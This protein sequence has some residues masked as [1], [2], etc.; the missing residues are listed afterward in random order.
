MNIVAC[1]GTH[2]HAT[3]LA[4]QPRGGITGV[5]ECVPGLLNE[6]ALLWIG[7]FGFRTRHLEKCR[8]EFVDVV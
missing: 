8:I 6:Q 1:G 4:V 5:F 3:T 7:V 2:E